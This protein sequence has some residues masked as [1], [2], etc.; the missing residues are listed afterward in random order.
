MSVEPREYQII[1]MS[2]LY[3]GSLDLGRNP[4]FWDSIDSRTERY[5]LRPG[6]ILMT[7]TGTIGK[8][9]YGYTVQL[10]NEKN[11]LLNQRVCC[12]RPMPH[13]V[14][15]NYLLM[16]L[17]TKAF[18]DN[19]FNCSIGGTGNQ[20][21][22]SILE[23]RELDVI[24]PHLAEQ[25]AIAELLSHWDEATKKIQLLIQAKERRLKWL[26]NS[27]ITR[28][29]DW[30][31]VRLGEICRITKGEQLN[32]SHMKASGAYYALNGGIEPSGRTNDWNTEAETITISEGGNSCGY[33]NYNTERFWAGGHCYSLL[34]LREAVNKQ[35]LFFYLKNKEPQLMKLRLGS[36][37]PN[38]QKK[39]LENFSIALPSFSE[40]Q[41]IAQLLSSTKQEISILKKNMQLYKIQKRGLMQRVLT[42]VWRAKP[43]IVKQYE[44][45]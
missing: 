8:R 34:G 4:S 16:Y 20:S 29:N 19:F 18:L 9:D 17:R 27:L 15:G 39:D 11:L 37:L 6:D 36:G 35:Y 38:I 22:V 43:E 14:N 12:I 23:L 30:K 31:E 10:Q 41:Q 33:V 26:V 25:K 1:K 28:G 24:L 3:Q 21:N 32:V 2:N 42:G 7:L 44:A 13:K 40:Q 45:V 5:I